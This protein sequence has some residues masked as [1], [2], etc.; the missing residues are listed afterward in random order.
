MNKQFKCALLTIIIMVSSSSFAESR[1]F[2][3][4]N[5]RAEFVSV[6]VNHGY[7]S[8]QSSC[9]QKRYMY[10]RIS[11]SIDYIFYGLCEPSFVGEVLQKVVEFSASNKG[12]SKDVNIN[13]YC[14]EKSE[15][16]N[17]KALFVQPWM[18]V[19]V[20]KK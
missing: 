19:E 10:S 4:R 1:E 14:E 8:D 2:G 11:T 7:C 16:T 9:M 18:T 20:N 15:T 13:I 12:E 17:L 5:L 3:N 6:L